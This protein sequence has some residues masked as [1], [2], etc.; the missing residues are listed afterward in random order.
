[1]RF[2]EH[3]AGDRHALAGAGVEVQ[4]VGRVRSA[5]EAHGVVRGHPI[6]RRQGVRAALGGLETIG[7]DK[8]AL[9]TQLI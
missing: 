8:G 1:M 5:T 4:T 2:D 6:S 9:H 3:L 7:Y